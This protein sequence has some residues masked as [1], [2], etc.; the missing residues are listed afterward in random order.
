MILY[1]NKIFLIDYE[2]I[3]RC[4]SLQNGKEI[5]QFGTE[6]SFIKSQR[7][8]SLIIQNGLVIFIETLGDINAL[9][10]NSGNLIWQSQTVSEDIFENTFLLKNSKLV[11]DNETIFISNNQN[12]FFAID[13]RNGIIKW[14]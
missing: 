6:K 10:I 1:D 5:W 2:N 3:I 11:S 13:V 12:K 4:I 9:D 14:E 7:K 8:L